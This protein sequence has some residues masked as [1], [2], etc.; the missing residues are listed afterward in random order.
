MN[1]TTLL[2]VR[3]NANRLMRPFEI[4]EREFSLVATLVRMSC[5][6]LL[7]IVLSKIL[8]PDLYGLVPN[9]LD[10]VFYTGYSINLDDVISASGTDH[11]FVTRW[12]SYLPAHF[13]SWMF[14][15]YWGRLALRLLMI[16]VLAELAWRLLAQ[17]KCSRVSRFLSMAIVLTTPMFVRAFTTEYSE[18]YLIWAG[19]LVLVLSF[20]STHTTTRTLLIG[21]LITS[22]VI[23]NPTSSFLCLLALANYFVSLRSDK[24][25]KALRW[26][27]VYLALSVLVVIGFGYFYFRIRYGLPNIYQPT[28]DYL[29]SYRPPK[30]D[31]WR[32]PDRVWLTYFGWIYLPI[33]LVLAAFFRLQK[34][35]SEYTN[36]L[37][38][39]SVLSLATYGFHALIETLSGHALETSYY[40]SQLLPQFF[41]FSCCSLQELFTRLV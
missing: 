38:R 19:L 15:P 4:D 22:I 8:R 7:V 27:L 20:G 16:V 6:L 24:N 3:L 33:I 32:A 36:T 21:S 10:P 41:C 17:L 37:W 29:T 2:F 39:C 14:G 31:G 1:R 18:Y 9:V 13:F 35:K 12:P 30:E 11:Y 28:I 26:H 25:L 34:E 5:W 40:W 23:T